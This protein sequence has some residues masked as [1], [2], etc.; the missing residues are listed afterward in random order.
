MRRGETQRYEKYNQQN[1]SRKLLKSRK[2]EAHPDTGG[3]QETK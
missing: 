3:L 2:R 1:N